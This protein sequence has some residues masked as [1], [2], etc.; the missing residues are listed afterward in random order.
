M[1]L[2]SAETPS[3]LSADKFAA[4]ASAAASALDDA[5]APKSNSGLGWGVLVVVVVALLA[6]GALLLWRRQRNRR[7]D[8]D[9]VEAVKRIDPT[10]AQALAQHPLHALDQL[11]KAIVVDV[12]NAV[13]TS[14]AQ[15]A[16]AA[17]E[18]STE[19]TAPFA[20]AVENAKAALAQAFTIRQ[21]LD[22]S[23]P[24]TPSQ[25]RDMLVE[26]IVSAARADRELEAQSTAFDQL[27][28]LVI[29]APERLDSLTQQ[30]VAVTARV[31]QSEQ[32]FTDLQ[33][34]FDATA[35]SSVAGNVAESK[36]LAEFAEQSIG[37]ARQL[38]TKPTEQQDGLVDAV[39]AAESAV[40][41]ANSLLGAVD[42]AAANIRTAVA[43][44]D[45]V[46]ADTQKGI[47]Q[48]QALKQS[49]LP[50]AAE[51][52]TACNAAV[53]AV[54]DARQNGKA[55]PLATFARL[56]KA[57]AELDK[58]LAAAQEE[59]DAADR[60]SRAIDQALATARPTV[61]AAS[62]FIELHRGIVSWQPR[63]NISEAQR[64]IAAAE[65]KRSSNPSEALAHANA[66]ISL[67]QQAQSRAGGD[68]QYAQQR[69]YS[70]R[71]YAGSGGAEIGGVIVGNILGS[72][73]GGMLSGGFGG[74]GRSP[75][76][77]TSFGGSSRSSGNDYFGGGGRF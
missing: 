11:S 52:T 57:D 13:R 55:D 1:S 40:N 54:D 5:L 30:L 45:A 72:M 38:L 36:Q 19:K 18:F 47:D 42:N 46:I 69:Q 62:D 37:T 34:E 26:S 24:E 22:D 9:E 4:A 41:Q 8:E 2:A 71:G 51:L 65:A 15:L 14:D 76:D 70:Y 17:E 21:R 63:T 60:L 77:P 67:A 66:A 56:S 28:D 35:L 32:T 31:P 10:D 12:D 20:S 58:V 6:V 48:A 61:A 44:M 33:K 7:R 73:L 68:V 59:K 39:R 49:D 50:H 53:V 29:N 3:S 27:R 64:H 74:G 16:L 25:R 43:Q 23:I 75:G